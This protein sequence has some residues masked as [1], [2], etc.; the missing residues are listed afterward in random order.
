MGAGKTVFFWI[1]FVTLELIEYIESNNIEYNVVTYIM[2]QRIHL[3]SL[4]TPLRLH[5]L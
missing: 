5:Y 4:F 3:Q 1:T 2:S